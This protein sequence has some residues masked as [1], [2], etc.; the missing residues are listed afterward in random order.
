[1][2]KYELRVRQHNPKWLFL[3]EFTFS[4][5]AV[6]TARKYLRDGWQVKLTEVGSKTFKEVSDGTDTDSL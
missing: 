4:L 5:F 6:L 3:Q 2:S 1:M